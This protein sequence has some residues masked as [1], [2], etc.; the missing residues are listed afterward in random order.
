[1]VTQYYLLTRFGFRLPKYV[2]DEYKV[3]T[4]KDL[5]YTENHDRDE[6]SRLDEDLNKILRDIYDSKNYGHVDNF[7]SYYKLNLVSE[8]KIKYVYHTRCDSKM[9]YEEFDALMFN[10]KDM[11][12]DYVIGSKIHISAE[13][14]MKLFYARYFMI[15]PDEDTD[16]VLRRY[17]V[18]TICQ[19]HDIG[20]IIETDLDWCR[21]LLEYYHGVLP[22]E[23]I[24]YLMLN[25]NTDFNTKFVGFC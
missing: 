10:F 7:V 12:Y 13:V 2:L 5:I 16:K 3:S 17:W 9:N 6:V 20:L 21:I 19:C 4:G 22:E 1:M 25:K 8:D 18:R 24:E 23:V 11:F 14:F 15:E